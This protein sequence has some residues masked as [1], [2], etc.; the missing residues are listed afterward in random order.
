LQRLVQQSGVSIGSAWNATK[1]L[2]FQPYKITVVPEIEHVDYE[3]RV[4]FFNW[5]IS[6]A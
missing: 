4:R 2:H 1:L 5:F 3:K 6:H